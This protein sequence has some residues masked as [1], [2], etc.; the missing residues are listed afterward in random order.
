MNFSKF[1]CKVTLMRTDCKDG[2][3][4]FHSYILFHIHIIKYQAKLKIY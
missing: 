4:L 3:N 2:I 1:I